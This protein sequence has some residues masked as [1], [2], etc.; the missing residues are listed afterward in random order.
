MREQQTTHVCVATAANGLLVTL[1]AATSTNDADGTAT[2][3]NVALDR[4][5]GNV[6]YA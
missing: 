4:V 2:H 3:C 6:Q 5:K 1:R